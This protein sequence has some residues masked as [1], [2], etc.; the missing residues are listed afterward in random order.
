M[1]AFILLTFFLV[2]CASL[3]YYID[4]DQYSENNNN[5][6]GSFLLPFHSLYF[7]LDSIVANNSEINV[8]LLSNLTISGN[9]SFINKNIKIM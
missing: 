8:F 3:D 1:K 6:D 2:F 4:I 9:F 5:N 7:L